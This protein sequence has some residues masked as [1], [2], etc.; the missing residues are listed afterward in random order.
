MA[1]LNSGDVRRLKKSLKD[2]AFYD[3]PTSGGF[4]IP[5]GGTIGQV[6]EKD[7]AVNYDASWH[8]P[9]SSDPRYATMAKYGGF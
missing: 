5:P 2:V 7:S 4:G 9:A 6:L 1:Q 3:L 8:T